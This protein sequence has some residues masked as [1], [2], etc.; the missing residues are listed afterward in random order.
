MNEINDNL[1]IYT[2]NERCMGCHSC[3]TACAIAHSSYDL[4]SAVLS[5]AILISRN[6]VIAMNNNQTTT[7]QCVQC[8]APCL[9]ACKSDCMTREQ[10]GIIKIDEENCIGCKLCF[11]ACPY[12]SIKMVKMPQVE[13]AEGK[14]KRKKFKAFKCDLCFDHID[15]QGNLHSAC[16]EACPTNAIIITNDNNYR[17]KTLSHRGY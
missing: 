8:E 5:G 7:S 11:K 9:D 10:F 15:E 4:H 16:V 12:D 1:F 14:K 13:S 2:D 3:E 6:K 17:E